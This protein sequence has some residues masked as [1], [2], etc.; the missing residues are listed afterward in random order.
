VNG[1]IT[2]YAGLWVVCVLSGCLCEV[3]NGCED[4]LLCQLDEALPLEA[5]HPSAVINQPIRGC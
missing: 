4:V 2:L 3:T 5:A 1:K